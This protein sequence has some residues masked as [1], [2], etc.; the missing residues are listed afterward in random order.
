MS[1]PVRQDAAPES[2]LS[3]SS[4]SSES[5][6]SL[7]SSGA[8]ESS[9][10]SE[11]SKSS[12]S[13]HAAD[14]THSA[15]TTRR[16]AWHDARVNLAAHPIAWP[17]A[18]LIG[19]AGRVVR[20][21]GLG[22]VVN[23]ALIAHDV[24]SRDREFTKRGPGS[25]AE[26][27]TQAFGPRALANMDGASHRE[28][29][30]RLGPLATVAQADVWLQ[31]ARRPFDRAIA[32][33]HAGEIVDVAHVARLLSGRLTLTL[34]GVVPEER[35]ADA[36]SL[37]VHALG[38]RIASTL[39]L[40]PVGASRLNAARA[41]LKRLLGYATDA[42]ER[43]DLPPES[44]VARLKTL[45]CDAQ[46]IH[47]ILSIFFVAGAL[48][49]GV[50]LPRVL[51]LLVDSDQLTLLREDESLIPRA[52]DEGLRYTCPV[53][54][55]VRMAAGDAVVGET[56]VRAGERVVILTAN[57]ARDATLFPDPGRF[58]VTRHQDPRSRYL[59]YG[60]GPHF[61]LGFTLAQRVLNYCVGTMARVP[62]GLRI[63][64]RRAARGV[65]LP[66]WKELHVQRGG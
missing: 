66:A 62:G 24:L 59:W 14:A 37:D 33:L 26:V 12:T 60:A 27:M 7:K 56:R 35:L 55:T 9:E 46:E 36:A 5:S 43:D 30:Q 51:G 34:M 2:L 29:R 52:V 6:E 44:L 64:R 58:D 31:S 61:C 22:V 57:L 8:S 16:A 32:S 21:P 10:S 40:S 1:A 50:A 53:P 11:S 20:L 45:G 42:F 23:D 3:A 19:A 65:L 18:R 48:T 54:A 49:L 41:D 47:G 15:S 25:I 17:A 63:V 13:V 4:E 38:E 28:L 39:R